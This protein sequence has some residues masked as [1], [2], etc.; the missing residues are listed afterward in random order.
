MAKVKKKNLETYIARFGGTLVLLTNGNY[1]IRNGMKSVNIGK[2]DTN[3]RW[4]D[5]Q[6]VRAW[7][8]ATDI[9]KPKPGE[10]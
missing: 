6:L 4:E 3:N 5:S 8:D 7:G 9:P 1:D 2:P 10:L